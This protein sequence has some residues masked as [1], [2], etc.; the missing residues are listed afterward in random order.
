V[1]Y[2]TRHSLK[3]TRYQPRCYLLHALDVCLQDF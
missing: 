3:A 2:E 1:G